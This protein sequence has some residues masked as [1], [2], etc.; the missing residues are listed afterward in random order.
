MRQYLI[1]IYT[2]VR[3]TAAVLFLMA[4]SVVK[5]QTVATDS[6][7]AAV[8]SLYEQMAVDSLS[9]KMIVDSVVVAADSSVS[10]MVA[11]KPLKKMREQRDWSTW[12]PD[13]QRALWLA[14]VFPGGGQ[15][16]NR[17]YWKLP[18]VYGGFIG[19]VYAMSWNSMM[20]K[21]YQQ[22]Y[23]DIMD[24]DPNTAS[25]NKFLH[26]GRQIDSS[27]MEHYKQIFKS[28]K[29]MYR[30]WR[31]LSFFAMVGVYALSVIDA[32]V[33]AELSEFDISKELSMKVR[34][35]VISNG[36]SQNPLYAASLGVNCSL[37][38]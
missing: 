34:P 31:D 6:V 26:L 32:Y 14:L 10:L 15:I 3:L 4:S 21:D 11:S 20:Y 22:A 29:D 33:D 19:C 12:R 24:D 37:N 1:Y 27:N 13:P 5:A 30:R 23:L 25:Y 38:F 28:R 7:V 8:D 2:R 9:E 17:K 35:A 16:Y 36:Q 18:L